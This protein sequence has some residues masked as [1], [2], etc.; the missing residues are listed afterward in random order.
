MT[1]PTFK[2]S[3]MFP[4][5]YVA[6]EDLKGRDVA[7]TIRRVEIA[8]LQMKGGGTEK[9]FLIHFDGKDKPLV[10]NKTNATT[11]AM[12]HG[13]AAEKWTGKR[14]TL[15]P[16]TCSAFGATTTCI[17]VR[18]KCPDDTSKP[19]ENFPEAD[20]DGDGAPEVDFY[21][22]GCGVTRV[23]PLGSR[24]ICDCGETMVEG[25]P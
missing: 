8:T 13:G 9:K 14:I 24:P 17:R 3:L 1:K 2:G 7:V 25:T 15:W 22:A 10:L 5:K 19:A 21:C 23:A 18:D 12:L 4:S 20:G 11:I 16:T 6:A